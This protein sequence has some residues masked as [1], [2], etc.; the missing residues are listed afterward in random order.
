MVLAGLV[1]CVVFCGLEQIL[2]LVPVLVGVL[3]EV[4][5]LGSGNSTSWFLVLRCGLF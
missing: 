5:R 1:F 4:K 3:G 2:V